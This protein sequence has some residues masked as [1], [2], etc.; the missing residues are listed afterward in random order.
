MQSTFAGIELGKRSLFAH[1]RGL[2]IVGHNLSNASVDGYSRQ[3]VEFQ[4]SS[5]LYRPGLNRAE[6]PGQIGQGVDIAR[7]ER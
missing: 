3:R 1:S 5:P 2:Q 4:P 7:I 6:T